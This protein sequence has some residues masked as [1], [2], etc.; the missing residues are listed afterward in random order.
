MAL[1][2]VPPRARLFVVPVSSHL[3]EHAMAIEE[4]SKSSKGLADGL[5]F[6]QENTSSHAGAP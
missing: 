6:G 1:L 5:A 2:L 4:V 3:V